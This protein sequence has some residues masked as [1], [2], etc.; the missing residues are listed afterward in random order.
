MWFAFL[1][2]A[3][4]LIRLPAKA[5][6]ESSDDSWGESGSGT[7]SGSSVDDSAADG[8]SEQDDDDALSASSAEDAAPSGDGSTDATVNVPPSSEPAADLVKI[9]RYRPVPPK[10]PDGDSKDLLRAILARPEFQDEA[11]KKKVQQD[12]WLQELLKRLQDWLNSLGLGAVAG[13][14]T[15]TVIAAVLLAILL[16]LL[17]YMLVRWIW[18][19]MASGRRIKLNLSE[20]SE[21]QLAA[22]GLLKLAEAALARGEVRQAIRLRFRAVLR[23]VPQA[24]AALL[25]T[26]SQLKRRLGRE[27]PAAAQPF[28]KLVGCFEDVWYGGVSASVEDYRTAD[29]WARAVESEIPEAVL[30]AAA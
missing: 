29:L 8:Y 7:T 23:R 10:K 17:L 13:S 6:A 24:S 18:D 15:A 27:Y 28:G 30:E 19:L 16:A 5:L 11:P 4:L 9:L 22:P 12:T 2:L 26:N 3:V 14:T 1:V 21:E 20:E 25:L